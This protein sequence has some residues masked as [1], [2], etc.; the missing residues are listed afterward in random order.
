MGIVQKSVAR[1]VPVVA[2]PFGRAQPEV[3]RRVGH[4]GGG[5]ALRAKRLTP[6]RL[7]AALRAAEAGRPAAAAAGAPPA[8]RRRSRRRPRS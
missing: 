8:A 3:A 6:A 7:R 4:S 2:V 1:G 5:V